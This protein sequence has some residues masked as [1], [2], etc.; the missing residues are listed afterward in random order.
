MKDGKM[1]NRPRSEWPPHWAVERFGRIGSQLL[2]AT[3]RFWRRSPGLGRSTL[4]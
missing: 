3:I 4:R 1:P 2:Q